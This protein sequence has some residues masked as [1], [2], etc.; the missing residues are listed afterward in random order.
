MLLDGSLKVD[1]AEAVTARRALKIA[2]E[3]GLRSVILESDCLEL[4]SI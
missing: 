1:E 3:S 4:V 2:M